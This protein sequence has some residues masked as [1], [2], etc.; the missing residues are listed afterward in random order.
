MQQVITIE[1]KRYATGLFWQPLT[2]GQN[3]RFFAHKIAKFVPG[4]VKFFTEYRGM[5]G[6]GS[7]ALGHRRRMG[8]AAVEVMEALSEYN[9]FLAVFAVKQGMYLIAARNGIIIT[10]RLYENEIDAKAEYEQLSTLPDWGVLVAPGYWSAPRSEEKL[11]EEVVSGESKQTIQPVS[12]VGGWLLSIILV[13][14]FLAGMFVMFKGPLVGFVADQG[15]KAK[16]DEA[17]LAEY[18]R[19]MAQ[20]D[21]LLVLPQTKDQ[22]RIELPYENLPDMFLRAEQCRDAITALM[23]IIPGWNQ[24]DA[25]CLGTSATVHLHRTYGAITDVYDFVAAAMPGVDVIENS[26]SDIVLVAQLDRLHGESRLSEVPMDVVA[27]SINSEFQLMGARVDV[28]PGIETVQGPGGITESVN[29]V[30]ATAG[31]KLEPNEFIKIFKDY[32]AVALPSIRWTAH[33]RTWNYEVKIYV[34]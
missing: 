5:V 2:N 21:K 30:L 8:V 24:V 1:R 34:K 10:D 32:Y 17:A 19:K 15:H 9:S 11:I 16:P 31:S 29:V 12:N 7:L 4:R 28:R 33:D 23:R 26:D 20:N 13:I 27:R 25:E 18:K 14:A 22:V 6:V 3:A